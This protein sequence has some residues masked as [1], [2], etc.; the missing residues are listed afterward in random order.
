MVSLAA[1]IASWSVSVRNTF[2][3]VDSDEERA[4]G[5]DQAGRDEQPTVLRARTA[6]LTKADNDAFS[7]SCHSGDSSDS[8]A[9]VDHPESP[10]TLQQPGLGRVLTRDPFESPKAL[11]VLLGAEVGRQRFESEGKGRT[12]LGRQTAAKTYPG[13][14][15]EEEPAPR[16]FGSEAR[17]GGVADRHPKANEVPR[18]APV[19]PV[20]PAQSRQ[21]AWGFGVASP[22]V[23][24]VPMAPDA[25]GVSNHASRATPAATGAA[26]LLAP[27]LPRGRVVPGPSHDQTTVMV[28]NLPNHYTR[29]NLMD[30]LDAEGFGGR[31]DFV[32]LPIDFQTHVALGYAFVNFCTPMDAECVRARLEGFTNWQGPSSKVCNI[33][34]SQ[35]LQGLALHVERYRNS[36]LMHELVPDIYRPVLFKNGMRV[37]F[38]PPTR[39]IKA[40]RK[41]TRLMLV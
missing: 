33:A 32:Y 25:V 24:F 29:D 20:L 41:G 39:R 35:H 22:M 30:L 3:H 13:P 16:F 11:P 31:Y 12:S 36:P 7:D 17:R 28:R 5:E 8:G 9:E 2:L 26:T 37:P 34:W 15:W 23:F 18:V 1:S 19:A 14:V 27:D 6:P 10:K 38:P 21:P 4:G 40:P